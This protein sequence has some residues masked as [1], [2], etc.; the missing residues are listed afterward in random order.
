MANLMGDTNSL[1]KSNFVFYQQLGDESRYPSGTPQHNLY[2]GMMGKGVERLGI[3]DF[4]S[5]AEKIA[6][7]LETQ[8]R[9]EG[10]KEIAM[11]NKEFNCNIT[12]GELYNKSIGKEIIYALNEALNLQ[13][14]FERNVNRIIG[15]NK[16][17]SNEKTTISSVLQSY[18]ITEL[19]Q[20]ESELLERIW[21]TIKRQKNLDLSYEEMIEKA[22]EKELGP[23]SNFVKSILENALEKALSSSTWIGGDDA[24]LKEILDYLNREENKSQKNLFLAQMWNNLGI[25]NFK[26]DLFEELKSKENLTKAFKTRKNKGLKMNTK[27]S[28]NKGTNYGIIGEH[29]GALISN[30]AMESFHGKNYSY[31]T[32]HT[33]RTGQMKADFTTAAGLDIRPVEDILSSRE[34]DKTFSDESVRILNRQRADAIQNYLKTLHSGFLIY[35]NVKDYGLSTIRN[36]GG[37]SSGSAISLSTYQEITESKNADELIGAIANTIKGAVYEGK[38]YEES[39]SKY[40]AEDIAIFLF[41]DAR[42]LGQKMNEN[43]ANAIHLMN[44]NGIYIPL[45]YFLF[46]LAEA[47]KSKDSEE[48]RNIFSPQIENNISI[49]YPNGGEGAE[50][51]DKWSE[52]DWYRQKDDALNR[53]KIGAHF[54]KNFVEMV[55]D[56]ALERF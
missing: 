8:A 48:Y 31:Q 56:F 14:V 41:D 47:F 27:V 10:E 28:I 45:S 30:I 37:F 17:G 36:M 21:R 53:V 9:N 16:K 52:D 3:N 2:V 29:L 11:L 40:I 50:G 43:T 44:L 23:Q 35:T 1:L 26:Q 19:N 22:I 13:K 24:P 5:R 55:K 6:S 20:R 32:I 38:K 46:L 34:F 7:I 33:G 15:K 12:L 54:S 42:V 51:L 4:S 49:K 25:R 39:L 18:V